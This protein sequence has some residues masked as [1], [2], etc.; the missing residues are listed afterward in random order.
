MD[1]LWIQGLKQ[2]MCEIWCEAIDGKR[3]IEKVSVADGCDCHSPSMSIRLTCGDGVV[4]KLPREYFERSV[5]KNPEIAEARSYTLQCKARSEI[6]EALLTAVADETPNG[7]ITED[8]FNELQNLCKELGFKGLAK[9]FRAFRGKTESDSIDIN[10]FLLLQE[11]IKR[12]DK[13]FAKIQDQ[14]NEIMSWKEEM[15][16][17]MRKSL[18]HQF[19]ALVRKIDEAVRDYEE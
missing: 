14:F 1:M 18:S 12:Y 5:F 13:Y 9:Q 6:V 4:V 10:E 2:F 17:E 15:E 3:V 7:T 8:N 16:S 19:R 11:R